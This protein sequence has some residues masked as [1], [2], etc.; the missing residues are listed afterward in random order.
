MK[1]SE[2]VRTQK[3][4]ADIEEARRAGNLLRVQQLLGE[5]TALLASVYGSRPDGQFILKRKTF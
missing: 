4:D 2:A 3:L 1:S 5:K